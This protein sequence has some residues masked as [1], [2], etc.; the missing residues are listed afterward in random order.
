MKAMRTP[1]PDPLPVRG[2][3]VPS[4]L[5]QV[6]MVSASL[7]EEGRGREAQVDMVSASPLDES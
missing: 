5:W 2:E 3:G 6:D 7:L 1:H 4:T